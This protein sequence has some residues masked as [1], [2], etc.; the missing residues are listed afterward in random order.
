MT[1]LKNIIFTCFILF[2]VRG[3]VEANTYVEEDIGGL[4]LKYI[5]YNIWDP[6]Y[7]IHIATS[8]N[9]TSIESLAQSKNA[10]TG[11]NGVF[12]CP[13]DYKECQWKDYTINERFIEGKDE[14]FYTDTGARWVFW[15]NNIWKPFI[16]QTWELNSDKRWEI[17][18]W[19]WNFPILLFEWKSKLEYYHDVWLYDTKMSSKSPRNF[20]CSDKDKK[21]IFFGRSSS[22]SLDDLV[23]VLYSLWCRDALNLDAWASSSMLINGQRVISGQRNILDWFFIEHTQIQTWE[24]D[25]KA[26]MYDYLLYK[27]YLRNKNINTRKSFKNRLISTFTQARINIEN[28]HTVYLYDEKWRNTWFARDIKSISDLKNLY[29][30]N[31]LEWYIKKW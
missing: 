21:N 28:K 30:I 3:C 17:Y 31:T 26:R 29:L 15:W 18:E 22:T 11:I 20:I 2:L 7:Q 6:N 10:I 5:Q 14:S 24:I 8:K 13:A 1:I 16:F 23:P 27:K 4:K 12:F 19:L 9:A 25:A